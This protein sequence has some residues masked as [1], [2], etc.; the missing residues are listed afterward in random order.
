VNTNDSGKSGEDKAAALLKKNKYKILERNWRTPRCEIDIV[1]KKGKKIY[2]CEVK[3]RKSDS[4]G[5]GSDY[6]T[7]K[8]LKQMEYAAKTWVSYNNYQGE[9]DLI[10]VSVSPTKAEILDDIWL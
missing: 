8:K 7:Y 10:V 4:Q 1:A 6:V 9:Y 5:E 2:F 3:Y